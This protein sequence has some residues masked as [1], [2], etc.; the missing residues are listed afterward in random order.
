MDIIDVSSLGAYI[1]GFTD[2]VAYKFVDANYRLV[3]HTHIRPLV[4]IDLIKR[5]LLDSLL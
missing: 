1:S 4:R 3:S 2:A 5:T